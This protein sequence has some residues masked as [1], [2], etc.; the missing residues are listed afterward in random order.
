MKEVYIHAWRLFSQNFL[1]LLIITLVVW[2]PCELAVSWLIATF[3]SADNTLAPM[4]L[5]RLANNFF[6]IIAIAASNYIFREK[7]ENGHASLGGAFGAGFLYWGWM[8][9]TRFLVGLATV[10]G[11]ILLILPG[12]YICIRLVLCEAIIVA[13]N[14]WGIECCQ[15]SMELTKGKFW[16]VLLWLLGGCGP[17]VVAA[18]LCY[19]PFVF[20]DNIGWQ[21]DALGSVLSDIPM[22][23][24]Y[25]IFWAIYT[26][27]RDEHDGTTHLPVITPTSSL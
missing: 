6:G 3:Y 19:L 4:K 9:A 17:A 26:K 11:L 27:L 2:I 24:I 7:E 18:F 22:I 16:R 25:P 1:K 20:V 21:L 13:E 15:R 12:L 5:E 8:F 23:F 10:V 14:T